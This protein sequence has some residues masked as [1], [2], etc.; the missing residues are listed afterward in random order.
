[1]RELRN[2]RARRDA[3]FTLVDLLFVIAIIGLI[4]SIA[5]PGMMR[6]RGAAQSASALATMRV[7]NSGELSF[8]ISC[9]LG[10]YAPDLPSLGIR[11]PGS[12]DAFLAPDL[13]G[14]ASFIK[15]GYEFSLA[16]TPL[17]G[18]PGSCNGIAPGTTAPSYAAVGD[19]LDAGAAAPRYFG[20]NSEGAIYEHTAS[21]A[22][23]MPENGPP[24][25]G[26]PVK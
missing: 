24:P 4:A 10:F 5:I 21:L 11:P 18:A 12:S 13:T 17:A 2:R 6:A 22:S 14:G 20:T 7:L 26:A 1:M 3:G 15:S 19:P 16:A 9:G 25:A 8:A 23:V